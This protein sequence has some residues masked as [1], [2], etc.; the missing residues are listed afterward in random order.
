MNTYEPLTVR[1]LPAELTVTYSVNGHQRFVSYNGDG[2]VVR[3]A[4]YSTDATDITL[5]KIAKLFHQHVS[6][7]GTIVVKPEENCKES[8]SRLKQLSKGV[9][10]TT[11]AGKVLVLSETA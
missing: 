8:A 3:S 10:A 6:N 1:I 11:L 9:R 5:R 4:L 2:K 7:G